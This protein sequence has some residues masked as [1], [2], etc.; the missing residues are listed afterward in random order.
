VNSGIGRSGKVLRRILGLPNTTAIN[1][2]VLRAVAQ[3]D[4]RTL[5]AAVNDERLAVLT[6]R[7]TWPVFGAGWARRVAEVRA[8]ALRMADAAAKEKA[9]STAVQ[10]G[11]AG[12]IAA[13]GAATAQQAHSSGAK[14]LVIGAIVIVTIMLALGGWFAWRWHQRRQQMARND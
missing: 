6:G 12:A 4:L 1:E 13:A 3:R 7:K 5:I 9:P 14:P 11:T 10:K 2:E 8:D